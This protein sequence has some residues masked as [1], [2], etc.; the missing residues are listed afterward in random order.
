MKTKNKNKM[1]THKNQG[2]FMQVVSYED[3]T[4]W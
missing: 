2:T 4:E 3:G 1:N